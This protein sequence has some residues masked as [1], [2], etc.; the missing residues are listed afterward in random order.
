MWIEFLLNEMHDIQVVVLSITKQDNI[1]LYAV[2]LQWIFAF[3]LYLTL[4]H[5]WFKTWDRY[6]NFFKDK[7]KL[8]TQFF[9]YKITLWSAI[10]KNSTVV[11]FP[12][13]INHIDQGSWW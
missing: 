12:I 5:V 6:V 9:G 3:V 1:V 4:A 8:R 2:V 7:T 13:F 10:K 11:W